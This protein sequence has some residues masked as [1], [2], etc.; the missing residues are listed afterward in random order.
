MSDSEEAPTPAQ[1]A[2]RERTEKERKAAEAAEQA[3]LPYT[4][5]QTIQDVDVSVPVSGNYKGR[6]MDVVLTK[7]RIKVAVKGQEPILEVYTI[8]HYKHREASPLISDGCDDRAN[9]HIPFT[10]TSHLGHSRQRRTL[11]A[12]KSRSTWTR[13]IRWSGGRM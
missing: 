7:T 12:R 11:Q 8:C 3:K 5:T 10:S 13:S 2:E 4:W 1:V 9:S 6:D